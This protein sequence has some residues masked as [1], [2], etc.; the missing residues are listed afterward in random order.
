M[1][2]K[3]PQQAGQGS[4]VMGL[5]VDAAEQDV[6]E[7]HPPA[8]FRH[9][10]AAI[11]EQRLNRIGV[12]GGDQGMAQALVW[13][14]QAHGEGELGSPQ[15]LSGPVCQGGQGSGHPHGADGDLPLGHAQVSAEAID[16]RQHR[17]DVEQRFSHT[18]EHHMAGAT[19]HR[20]A[21]AQH[22]IDDLVWRQGPLQ[23]PFA[24]GAEAAGHRTAHLAADTDGEPLAGGNAYGLQGEPI[25]GAEQ[26]FHGAIDRV[27]AMHQ[28]QAS[29]QAW[30]QLL[31]PALGQHRDRLGIAHATGVD[32][33]MQLATA[34]GRLAL[35]LGPLLQ[36][37]APPA[38]QGGVVAE[39]GGLGRDQGQIRM[40]WLSFHS[41]AK[42]AMKPSMAMRPCSFSLWAWKP[43]RG[44]RRWGMG[45]P[46][47][48]RPA[49]G[50]E[51]VIAQQP[52]LLQALQRIGVGD[53]VLLQLV[54]RRA[55]EGGETAGGCLDAMAAAGGLQVL[56]GGVIKHRR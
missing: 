53:Q 16:C 6:L 21:H 25:V 9:V 14:M 41:T 37:V 26:Q 17:V 4:G 5:V 54:D 30:G 27:A 50:E 56:I 42:R 32:P 36:F 33:L 52:L 23:P 35:G 48:V 43:Q 3:P 28:G 8:G 49:A 10:V 46:S 39:G 24:G 47:S 1:A 18:H 15:A 12:G 29:D 44:R 13:G 2:L 31:P 22:L 7:A 40:P 45:V 11:L 38:E 34:E 19:V 55:D 20:L 51:S